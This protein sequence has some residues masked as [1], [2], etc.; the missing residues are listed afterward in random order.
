M[1]HAT[2]R[3]RLT[4][5]FLALC[6][7]AGACGDDAVLTGDAAIVSDAG[8]DAATPAPARPV[9]PVAA[10]RA[11]KLYYKE[12]VERVLT[13]YNRFAT[14]GDSG[15]TNAIDVSWIARDGDDYEVVGGPKDNNLIGTAIFSTYQA[16]RAL[17]TRPLAL[18]LV[19][20]FN[21]LVFFE[22][23]SGIPGLTSREVLPGWTRVMDGVAGKVTRTRGGKPVVHPDPPAKDL[24]AE[25][26][27]MFYAGVRVTYREDPS[28]YYFAFM[29][30]A[31]T[32]EYAVTMSFPELG[33]P[34]PEPNYL[35]ASDCCSSFMQTPANE[36]WAGA[37][38]GNHNSRDNFPDLAMGILAALEASEDDEADADVREAAKRALAA[39]HRMGDL[40]QKHGGRIMTSDEWHPYGELTVSGE[41]GPHGGTGPTMGNLGAIASCQDVYLA[42]AITTE[43]LSWPVPNLPMPGNVEQQLMQAGL[44]CEYVENRDCVGLDDGYCGLRVD[45]FDKLTRG[46]VEVVKL[47]RALEAATPGTAQTYIGSFQDDYDD[48]VEAMMV[49]VHYARVVGDD[50][51]REEAQT[52]LKKMS[53]LQREFADLIYGQIDPDRQKRQRF[54]AA[55]FDALGGVAVEAADLGDFTTEEQSMAG[56]EGLLDMPDTAPAALK[57]DQE[58]SDA[59]E[60]R[61]A[62]VEAEMDPSGESAIVVQ[63][64]RDAYGMQAPLRRKGD[65]YEAKRA[66]GD[67]V[68][69]EVPRHM[70]ISN[71]ELMQ[72]IT[73]CNISPD[74]LDCSWAKLG[75]ERPDLTHDGKVDASDRDV[76]DAVDTKRDCAPANDWCDGADLDRSGDVDALDRAFM[77]AAQDCH[78]TR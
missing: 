76:F 52:T 25:V 48:V 20:M 49:L 9:D 17:R 10:G 19:R 13:A 65:G 62:A 2:L 60:M 58:I 67:W 11:F 53:D 70:P 31:N 54:D 46:G 15:F 59:V 36:K 43:G 26:L 30:A 63:R 51:L 40:I 18:T 21:G 78:Y 72:P 12:R 1:T 57:T 23:V 16:Y 14:F 27:D 73:I 66:G 8:T 29:P 50:E 35:R 77:D 69:V 5:V 45:N 47:V 33:H 7:G 22:E 32:V 64:Y 3:S 4:V 71:L 61:L 75:C 34:D 38:W 37:F 74:V 44:D 68:P 6:V 55:V 41:R 56:F 24:E 42:Q 39:G 28:D